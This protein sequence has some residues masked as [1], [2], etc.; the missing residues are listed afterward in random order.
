MSDEIDLRK[1][2]QIARKEADAAVQKRRKRIGNGQE[3]VCAFH[4]PI[5]DLRK[6]GQPWEKVAEALQRWCGL[7]LS[8]NTVKAYTSKVNIGELAPWPDDDAIEGAIEPG[9]LPAPEFVGE[10]AD[11]ASP[12][13]HPEDE[14]ATPAEADQRAKTVGRDAGSTSCSAEGA[15]R[16][17]GAFDE[18]PDPIRKRT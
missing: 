4:A 1:A 11:P 6:A 9:P 12:P 2:R 13:D 7:E 16:E 8:A 17:R 15:I 5:L 18:K 10:S 3:A 14:R